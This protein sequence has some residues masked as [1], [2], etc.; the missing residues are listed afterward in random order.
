VSPDGTPERDDEV[1]LDE[2]AALRAGELSAVEEAKLQMRIARDPEG[3]DKLWALDNVHRLFE[4]PDPSEAELPPEM[5]YHVAARLQARIAEEALRRAEQPGRGDGDGDDP[6]ES[7][8]TD[9][10]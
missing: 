5:P 10:Q 7:G 6:S 4:P 8:P 1:T 9:N 3:A 2:L